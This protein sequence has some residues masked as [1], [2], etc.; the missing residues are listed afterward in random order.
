MARVYKYLL[1]DDV[2][3]PYIEESKMTPDALKQIIDEVFAAL[4][5]ATAGNIFAHMAVS[6][7]HALVDTL[8][9]Q[10]A[11]ALANKGIGIVK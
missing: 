11:A 6:V 1:I 4:E 9:P 7:V 2:I 3:Y 5:A 10:I 8:L